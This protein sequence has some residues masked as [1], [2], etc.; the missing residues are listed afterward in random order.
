MGL[1]RAG[2]DPPVASVTRQRAQTV[3]IHIG[4]HH[5]RELT[6]PKCGGGDNFIETGGGR[7]PLQYACAYG[8]PAVVAL[9]VKRKRSVDLYD[10]DG[11]T[12]LMKAVQYEEEECA[13]ILLKKMVPIQMFTKTRVKLL[14]TVLCFR[15]THQYQQNCFH[16]LQILKPRI[17]VD[18]HH[19]YSP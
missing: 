7:T 8:N 10:S 6:S 9:L 5:G 3:V 4:Y 15:G 16:S 13:I 19:F 12:P 11:N 2:Q 14:S 18:K 1:G 17:R